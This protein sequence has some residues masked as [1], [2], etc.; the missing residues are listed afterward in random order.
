VAEVNDLSELLVPG[1]VIVVAV[2][3]LIV[4]FGLPRL[5]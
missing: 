3:V 1:V 5:R 4:F 2:V